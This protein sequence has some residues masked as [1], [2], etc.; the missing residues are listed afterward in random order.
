[1]PVKRPMGVAPPPPGSNSLIGSPPMTTVKISSKIQMAH[2]KQGPKMMPNGPIPAQKMVI[3]SPQ[4]MPGTG[5]TSPK[6]PIAP[7][8]GQLNKLRPSSSTPIAPGQKRIIPSFPTPH[9][10]K[11]QPVI[12]TG[13]PGQQPPPPPQAMRVKVNCTASSDMPF[14]VSCVISISD[15]VVWVGHT[16]G[17][18]SIVNIK[19]N[20][21]IKSFDAHEGNGGV[22]CMIKAGKKEILSAGRGVVKKWN[23]TGDL[24]STTSTDTAGDVT[25]FVFAGVTL[26]GGTNRGM[27][28]VWNMNTADY[29]VVDTGFKNQDIAALA[30]FGKSLIAAVGSDL[31]FLSPSAQ[32]GGKLIVNKVV[33]TP[34]EKGV[35]AIVAFSP[36]CFVT[37]DAC[38]S[39]A[40]RWNSPDVKAVI[41]TASA[42]EVDKSS[43]F[44]SAMGVNR[45]LV[46]YARNK[47]YFLEA[48]N[49]RIVGTCPNYSANGDEY[50][51]SLIILNHF[52]NSPNAKFM[53]A[54]KH[55][56]HI[57]V[58]DMSLI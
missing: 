42:D 31:V 37:I 8:P 28:C 34:H 19:S 16:D 4:T 56:I 15:E 1:M 54:P 40:I 52:P 25:S 43:R 49:G 48:L 5:V 18:I 32:D 46:V 30:I 58:W 9:I 17:Q 35:H 11:G 12:G 38:F 41:Y 47:F 50:D 3:K 24:L 33:K 39:T 36:V 29:Y 26:C 44:S 23:L 57:G 7:P 45:V 20:N 21:I 22:L 27:I 51:T 55:N 14:L 13:V 10:Q 2:G 53:L 6:M